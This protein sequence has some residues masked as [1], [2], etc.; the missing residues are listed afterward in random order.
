MSK[1]HRAWALVATVEQDEEVRKDQEAEEYFSVGH[2][3][4]SEEVGFEPLY[5]VWAW[6]GGKV[7][8]SGVMVSE[9]ME[10]EDVEERWPDGVP[11]F[12]FGLDD[13]ETHGS[14]W[15]HDVTDETYKGRYEP[16]TGRLTVVKPSRV[17]AQ[18]RDV[19]ELIMGNLHR[20]F[21]NISKTYVF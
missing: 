20:T 17:M 2:G 16:E 18:Q 11:D 8:T 12:G 21:G 19:P 10:D 14:L 7:R 13:V 4:Y 9:G 5:L 3:D 1:Y 6:I 15:G